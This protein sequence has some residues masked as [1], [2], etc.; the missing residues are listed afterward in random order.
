MDKVSFNGTMLHIY[1]SPKSS[2]DDRKRLASSLLERISLNLS[3]SKILKDDSFT[4]SNDNFDVDAFNIVQKRLLSF[5]KKV[6]S[7]LKIFVIQDKKDRSV[8]MLTV[9][10]DLNNELVE[11]IYNDA[12]LF[13]MPFSM[14]EDS[15]LKSNGFRIGK[16]ITDETF[17]N[18]MF[19]E[20]EKI[21]KSRI[22][23]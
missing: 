2:L 8:E 17:L 20:A 12:P 11:E 13:N 9:T 21:V 7:T 4:I 5:F 15:A 10:K 3:H 14:L 18:I 22:S 23:K 16:P 19:T 1:Q 6:K